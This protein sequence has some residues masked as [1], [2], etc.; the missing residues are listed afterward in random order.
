MVLNC[1]HV[2]AQISDYIDGN[3]APE[4]REAIEE[5]L[6]HCRHCAAVLDS[7]RNILIL[8]ADDRTFELPVG[9]SDRLHARLQEEIA[10]SEELE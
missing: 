6:A 1:K 4:L 3:V 2:W 8:I 10:S 7:T 5:H 9:Y